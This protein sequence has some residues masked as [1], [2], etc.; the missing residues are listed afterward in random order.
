MIWG[1]WK[2]GVGFFRWQQ[3]SREA[4]MSAARRIACSASSIFQDAYKVLTGGV[5]HVS[6]RTLQQG[7]DFCGLSLR[8]HGQNFVFAAPY[9]YHRR[10]G[11]RAWFTVLFLQGGNINPF[12]GKRA[13]TKSQQN[14]SP[15]Q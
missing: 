8:A 11:L 3:M 15:K 9:R 13:V 6:V 5:A 2:T 12:L 7:F 1:S 4:S 10:F 14:L